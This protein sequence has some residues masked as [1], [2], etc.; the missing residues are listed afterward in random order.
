MAG[1]RA[2]QRPPGG[3]VG[4]ESGGRALHVAPGDGGRLIVQ[5]LCVG[6]RGGDRPHPAGLHVE[7]VEEGAGKGERMGRRADVV[8]D[9]GGEAEVERAG[10][11]ADRVLGLQHLHVEARTG[12]GHRGGEPVG[13]G[14]H[15]D[16]IDLRGGMGA[17][18][19]SLE[20]VGGSSR[21]HLRKADV[22]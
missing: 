22:A 21:T 2:E 10:T 18:L 16:D 20:Q 11:A 19:P 15:D 9:P 13:A 6:G 5:R 14:P 17:H 3:S 8:H 7:G 4:P 12:E 1:Q